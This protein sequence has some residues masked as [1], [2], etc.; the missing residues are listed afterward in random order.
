MPNITPRRAAA[1]ALLIGAGLTLAPEARA[2][3]VP[4][5]LQ[6]GEDVPDT[7]FQLTGR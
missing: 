5:N 4:A 7:E 6:V 2:A 1:A 3:G